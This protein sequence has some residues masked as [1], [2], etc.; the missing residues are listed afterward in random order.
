M[1]G[2]LGPDWLARPGCPGARGWQVGWR[3]RIKPDDAFVWDK[4]LRPCHHSGVTAGI[5]R[6]PIP[7]RPLTPGPERCTCDPELGVAPPW[8]ST[9]EAQPLVGVEVCHPHL[10]AAHQL[11]ARLLRM[12]QERGD[13]FTGAVAGVVPRLITPCATTSGCPVAARSPSPSRWPAAR[14]VPWA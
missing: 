13:D 9:R 3:N 8:P 10:T 5:S 11:G 14:Y 6:R 2:L 1:P 12:L 7:G 4:S